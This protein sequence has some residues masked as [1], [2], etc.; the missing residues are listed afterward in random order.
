MAGRPELTSRE[1]STREL[2]QG[3]LEALSAEPESTWPG[4]LLVF[5]LWG[6]FP[7]LLLGWVGRWLGGLESI[8]APVIGEVVG[9]AL[10]LTLFAAMWFSAR[11]SS[12]SVQRLVD[13]D[14]RQ[15]LVEVVRVCGARFTKT[16]HPIDTPQLAV[17]VGDGATLFLQGSWLTEAA[18]FG[19]AEPDADSDWDERHLNGQPDP[20]GFPSADFTLHRLPSSGH[21]VRVDVEGPYFDPVPT[22]DPEFWRYR[23]RESEWLGR[24]GVSPGHS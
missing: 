18:R 1:L 15:G 13:A 4:T 16:A 22:E 8:D 3:E 9:W 10:G 19:R 23:P 5:T 17:E 6:L 11:R 14:L 12:D 24:G 20:W 2:T 7:G 21:V